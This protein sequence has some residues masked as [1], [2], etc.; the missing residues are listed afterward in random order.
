SPTLIGQ[1]ADMASLHT[2]IAINAVP[3]LL[4]G[5]A[6]LVGAKLFREAVP[7]ARG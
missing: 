5:M 3:V 7:Q 4:G 1:I 2:A 6:L